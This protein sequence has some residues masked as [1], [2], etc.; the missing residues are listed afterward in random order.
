MDDWKWQ[1]SCYYNDSVRSPK[2]P[3]ALAISTR[4]KTDA[5]K[6]I[7]VKAAESRD[8]I[9]AVIVTPIPMKGMW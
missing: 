1:V 7:E 3:G 2:Q 4:H 5:S 9:G 6:D 8:D